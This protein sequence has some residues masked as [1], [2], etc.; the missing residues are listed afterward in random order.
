[1]GRRDRQRQ[2]AR[3]HPC[4]PDPRTDF[5]VE[6]ATELGAAKIIPV[7]TDYTQGD[8]LRQDKLQAHALEATEQCGGTFV[9]EVTELTKLATLLDNWPS[10]RKILFCDEA[11]VGQPVDLPKDKAPWAI[12]I[13]PEG[14]FSE[15]ER[16]ALNAHPN[17]HAVALGPRI[18]RA[19]TAAV[20]ALTLWQEH[21]GDWP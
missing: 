2:Q 17:A 7:Q 14:G 6:K 18:L 5:I 10:D 13:G 11:R 12:L 1:M 19:D 4:V 16:K 21:L 15:P 20:A 9:P 8:R 3:R